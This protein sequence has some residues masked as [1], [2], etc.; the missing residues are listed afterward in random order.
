MPMARRSGGGAS[1]RDARREMYRQQVLVAAEYEFAKAGFTE[2]RVSSIAA[3]ADISLATLYKS[4]ASKDDI[5][6][7]LNTQRMDELVGMA[8]K[9]SDNAESPSERILLGV[10]AQ[11]QFFAQHPNFLRL[12][13]NESWSWATATDVGR[14][15][16]RQVWRT[17][18]EMMTH[19]VE[20][21]VESDK[22]VAGLRPL[23][24]AR[25]AV[26][27]LQVWL[28]EWVENDT[29]RPVDEVADELLAHLGRTLF[30]NRVALGDLSA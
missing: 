3:T 23:T 1:I 29:Q 27:A 30:T 7:A 15:G 12:H 9:A 4:F 19:A 26:S 6:N 2:T 10:R 13:I 24:A 5:W 20:A 25:L 22:L 16:Q 8:R 18:I 17:G 11:V 21:A 14:G 28:T